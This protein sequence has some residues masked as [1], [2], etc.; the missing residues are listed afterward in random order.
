MGTDGNHPRLLTYLIYINPDWKEGDG[1]TYTIYKNWPDSVVQEVLTPTLGKGILFRADKVHH[2]GDLAR[3]PKRAITL[4]LNI[5]E[6]DIPPEVEPLIRNTDM[7]DDMK[8]VYVD[9]GLEVMTQDSSQAFTDFLKE[10]LDRWGK[11]VTVAGIKA[12]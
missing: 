2:S 10:Q 3:A 8:K 4:F 12:E 5:K 9:S 7:T 1:G 6:V 11:V